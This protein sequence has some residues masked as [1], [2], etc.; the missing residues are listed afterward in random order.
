MFFAKLRNTAAA[1]LLSMALAV[2]VVAGPSRYSSLLRPMVGTDQIHEA[3]VGDTLSD[4]SHR[5]G[6]ALEHVTWANGL[7][8]QEA[9]PLGAMIKIPTRRI[10]P[11]N[12]PRDGIVLNI[13][14][15][16]LYLFRNGHFDHFYP[17]AVGRIGFLTPRGDFH[18]VE[19]Q[20]DPTWF[21]PSWAHVPKKAYGPGPDDPLG[22]RWIGLSTHGVGIH[23][24][25]SPSSIGM[26][27]SHGCIR[28]YP[29]QIH[30]L[31]DKV[32][33]GMPVRIEYETAKLGYDPLTGHV[34]LATFPDIYHLE[35]PV[36]RA[37]HLVHEA[38]LSKQVTDE[39]V[40][41]LATSQNGRTLLAVGNDIMIKVAGE[42]IWL[43]VAPVRRGGAVWVPL[44]VAKAAG[45]SVSTS[46]RTVVIGR[47]QERLTFQVMGEAP[48]MAS[49]GPSIG[50]MASAPEDSEGEAFAGGARAV[51][52]HAYTWEGHVMVPAQ[53]L[54]QYFSIP[55]QWDAEHQ[56]LSLQ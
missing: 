50:L 32:S 41:K 39:D 36:A 31:F 12:P 6:L 34:Y 37:L 29:D 15:R 51:S 14:E 13:P 42:R 48:P 54:F 33:I 28:V 56:T 27:V 47:D 7:E 45:L 3:V 53:P 21:P 38:G 49:A 30:E 40:R 23:G 44:E 2:P 24:T 20:K 25:Q 43:S 26:A 52:Q 10:L 16:C 19:K 5:Y 1:L 9:L 4:V 35:D 46:G 11:A 22:D 17:V 18:I 55:Y 8:M